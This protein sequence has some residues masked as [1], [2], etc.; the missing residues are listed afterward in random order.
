MALNTEQLLNRAALKAI[1]KE[2]MHTG[3]V[4]PLQK[5]AFSPGAAIGDA[6]G[7]LKGTAKTVAGHAARGAAA[8]A[9]GG[10]TMGMLSKP[11]HD[12]SRLKHILTHAAKGALTGAVIGAPVSAVMGSAMDKTSAAKKTRMVEFLKSAGCKSDEIEQLKRTIKAASLM[13]KQGWVIPALAG[14][15]GGVGLGLGSQM[16]QGAVGNLN[17]HQMPASRRALYGKIHNQ[18]MESGQLSQDLQAIKG[19]FNPAPDPW[20]SGRP[21][22]HGM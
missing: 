12:K 11:E 21:Q 19:S 8:G 22:M 3:T 13:K 18:A 4:K 1:V 14:I 5:K 2:A 6:I 17:Q 7:G 15:A 9:A 16:L 20:G 10:A